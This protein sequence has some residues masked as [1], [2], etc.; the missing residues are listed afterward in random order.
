VPA[1]SS[2]PTA[3]TIATSDLRRA[4]SRQTWLANRARNA[5]QR[6]AFI[7]AISVGTFVTALVSMVVVPRAQRQGAPP[8]RIAARPDTFS[9]AATAALARV[10]LV[11]TD[12]A[13]AAAR[14]QVATVAAQRPPDTLYRLSAVHR[15]SLAARAAT[16]ERLVS[17]AEQAPLPSSYKALAELPELRADSRIR[18][19][20][21]SLSEIEREREGFGAVGGVDPIFVALTSRANEIGRAIQAIANDRLKAMRAELEPSTAPA[22]AVVMTPAVDTASR[23]AERDSAQLAMSQANDSLIRLR[24]IAHELDLEETRARERASAVAPPLAF[25]ASAF[26][27]SAVIGFATALIGELRR[28]RVTD[29]NELERFLG[30]RVL[31]SVET[32]MPSA[33]RG[34]READRAAPPYFDPSA[35]GYQLAYL[36]LATEHPTLLAATITGDDPAI[37]AVVA[38]NLAAISADEARNTLVVDLEPSCSV[39][40]ALRTRVHPGIVDILRGDV[41]WPDVTI[42]AAVGRDKTVDLVPYG[43]GASAPSLAPPAAPELAA[44]LRKD[45]A[46]LARYYDAIFV[47][48]AP[49]DTAAG[50]PAALPSPDVVFCAQPGITPLRHLRDCLEGIRAAGGTVRGIV[51]WN[52]ERPLLPTPTELASRARRD[53]TGKSQV[54]IATT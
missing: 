40:A 32:Q 54:A 14:S 35:E 34:R 17:R 46:R 2:Q 13:L 21:D 10:R 20:V 22:P 28:P 11:E 31:S 30:V 18:A 25:L 23:V 39:S 38:C 48:A 3:P 6:P 4:I 49:E 50:L 45:A 51:L 43:A 37:A 16:L 41:S 42:A 47:A 19:L 36:G 7:G 44:L 1:P 24:Q 27:L 29:A 15:D 33:E 8:I 12:S 5:L 52:A 53:R 9:I 26:V